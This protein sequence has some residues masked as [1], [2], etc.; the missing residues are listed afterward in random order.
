L[1]GPDER[2]YYPIHRP[3]LDDPIKGIVLSAGILGFWTHWVVNAYG[4]NG[5]TKPC[6]GTRDDGLI[7]QWCATGRHGMHWYGFVSLL[8]QPSKALVGLLLHSTGAHALLR[9]RP[10][11]L[12]LRGLEIRV[13]K[14]GP[15]MWAALALSQ[16]GEHD[17]AKLPPSFDLTESLRGFWD[18]PSLPPLTAPSIVEGGT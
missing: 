10:E 1:P 9:L 12:S 8:T 4:G 2:R 7:C 6:Q 5:R 14:Q 17:P 16:V 3:R 13:A 18:V 15:Q 11:P